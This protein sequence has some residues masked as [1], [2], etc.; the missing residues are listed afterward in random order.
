MH[1]DD[2]SKNVPDGYIRVDSTVFL[3][4]YKAYFFPE[5]LATEPDF[6]KLKTYF[7]QRFIVNEKGKEKGIHQLRKQISI[8][9]DGGFDFDPEVKQLLETGDLT[10]FP[11]IV[12][13]DFYFSIN[14][15]NVHLAQTLTHSS[16]T[17]I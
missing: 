11:I 4:E 17:G 13:N 6:G 3:F 1:F 15:L 5:K 16:S 10:I 12:F 2:S 7:D 9:H 14:G 8:I